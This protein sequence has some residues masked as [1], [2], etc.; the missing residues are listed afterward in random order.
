MPVVGRLGKRCVAQSG[1]SSAGLPR[2]RYPR[3][4]TAS[5]RSTLPSAFMSPFTDEHVAPPPPWPPPAAAVLGSPSN[6]RP[7][8]KLTPAT[9]SRMRNLFMTQ[10]LR[11]DPR[12]PIARRPVDSAVMVSVRRT[13]TA[14]IPRCAAG[15]LPR[16]T[17]SSLA[18]DGLIEKFL[19]HMGRQQR[20]R[21]RV[22]ARFY[23]FVERARI[24]GA[25]GLISRSWTSKA[26]GG[27]LR[28]RELVEVPLERDVRLPEDSRVV[29]VLAVAAVVAGEELPPSEHR[30]EPA[31]VLY[32][33]R[34]GVREVR[35]HLGQRQHEL[36]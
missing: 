15:A 13:G 32:R 19:R 31:A 5:D 30:V 1:A 10:S 11:C 26:K 8:A 25:R 14:R 28:V 20:S 6:I 18:Q 29:R 17:M 21:S 12:I 35:A 24:P 34:D 2:N 4:V 3:I 23:L 33:H 22:R 16:D 36:R 7:A 9:K 27:A